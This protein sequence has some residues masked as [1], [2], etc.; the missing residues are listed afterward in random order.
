MNNPL[1]SY[2]LLPTSYLVLLKI[3]EEQLVIF[4]L[5]NEAYGINVAQ[6]QSIIP[7]PDIVTIP[8]APSFI[9]GVIN[10]RG[11]VVPVV[12]L[13]ARFGLPVADSTNGRKAVIIIIEL[14]KLQV[15]LIVDKVTEVTKMPASAIEPPS[16]LLTTVDTAYLRGIGKFKNNLVILLDLERIFSDFAG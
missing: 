2:L 14:H 12:D 9:E 1:P 11:A 8:G 10:L 16:A 7:L 13:R 3:M 4:R 15:G 6:V 5:N